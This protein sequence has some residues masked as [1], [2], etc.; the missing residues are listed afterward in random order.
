MAFDLTI[1]VAFQAFCIVLPAGIP[2]FSGVIEQVLVIEKNCLAVSE[3][4][5]SSYSFTDMK[6]EK[7]RWTFRAISVYSLCLSASVHILTYKKV[8]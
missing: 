6:Y 2:I 1:R 3:K 4:F 7:E 5:R 8:A